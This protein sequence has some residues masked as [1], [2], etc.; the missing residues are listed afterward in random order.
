MNITQCQVNCTDGSYH[1]GD[2]ND[3]QYNLFH[4]PSVACRRFEVLAPPP[5]TDSKERGPRGVPLVSSNYMSKTNFYPIAMATVLRAKDKG[6]RPLSPL[7]M[8]GGSL[9]EKE[10]VLLAN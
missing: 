1:H 7:Q 3:R 10:K 8:F 6:R 5:V 4:V 9:A 2:V